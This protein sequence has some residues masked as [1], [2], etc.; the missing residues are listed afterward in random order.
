MFFSGDAYDPTGNPR[1]GKFALFSENP[2]NPTAGSEIQTYWVGVEDL[3]GWDAVEGKGDYN[4][5]IF[6][7][8]VTS[9]P[10][11]GFLT[12]IAVELSGALIGLWFIARRRRSA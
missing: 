3:A 12:W 2:T 10:E 1:S 11:P 6:R 8:T 5:L 7:A 4:D 9:V